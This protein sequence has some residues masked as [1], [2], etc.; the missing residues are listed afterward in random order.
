MTTST[1]NLALPAFRFG[2]RDE[3]EDGWILPVLQRTADGY[4][5]IG[6]LGS[7]CGA[8]MT[9]IH[10]DRA[11]PGAYRPVQCAETLT[12]AVWRIIRDFSL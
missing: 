12:E 7:W 10:P 2:A 1:L 8:F 11:E 5:P 4:V 3:S 6:N 9:A